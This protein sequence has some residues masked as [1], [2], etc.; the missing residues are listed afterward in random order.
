[1]NTILPRFIEFNKNTTFNTEDMPHWIAISKINLCFACIAVILFLVVILT[2][3]HCIHASHKIDSNYLHNRIYNKKEQIN[4]RKQ[5]DSLVSC[6]ITTTITCIIIAIITAIVYIIIF[7]L[8]SHIEVAYNHSGFQIANTN[9][10]ASKYRPDTHIERA[11]YLMPDK[12]CHES[13]YY[14][15][16]DLKNA[17]PDGIRTNHIVNRTLIGISMTQTVYGSNHDNDLSNNCH[18]KP[19]MGIKQNV[20]YLGKMVNGK[21]IPNYQNTKV[22]NIFMNY[23]KY[24]KK[25]HL[26]SKFKHHFSF[27]VS[28]KYSQDNDPI[29]V[30]IGDHGFTLHYKNNNNTKDIASN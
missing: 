19:D 28:Q 24:I 27:E 13:T 5:K 23:Q 29:L 26:E 22:V 14:V 11:N 8:N 4:A 3:Y 2:N 16:V 12:N 1:M 6:R 30:V 21:F 25:H 20:I 9:L 15:Y 10:V 17:K 7:S 18:N